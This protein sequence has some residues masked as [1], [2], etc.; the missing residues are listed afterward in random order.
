MHLDVIGI[1]ANSPKDVN[2]VVEI[3]LGGSIKY[4]MDK[5]TGLLVV[6]RFISTSMFYPG[7]Y[8]FIPQTLSDDGDPLDV[9]IYHSDPLLLGSIISV[10]PIGV[11][12][13]E[14]D[15]GNDEKILAV[16]SH[17]IT[18]LYDK[19]HSYKD[20]PN[21]Y[22]HKVEHF[23]QHYKDLESGK[24]AKL[25]G[26]EGI[27]EAHKTI[28]EAMKKHDGLCASKSLSSAGGDVSKTS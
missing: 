28:I 16:P 27:E 6:D 11:M 14:D 17:N 5:N 12:I 3:A 21:S 23:F 19:I 18:G 1:G 13:M 9:M 26:W 24:W 7:N 15:G 4:E 8:G 25:G 22:L 10:R 20:I 2:V